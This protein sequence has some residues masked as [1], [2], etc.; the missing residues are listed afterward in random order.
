MALF[1]LRARTAFL[2]SLSLANY[3]EFGLIVAAIGAGNG[4]LGPEWLTIIAIALSLSF[5]AASPLN[6][7][8]HELYERFRTRLRRVQRPE[9]IAAEAEI[10]PGDADVMV[11]GM[12]RVGTGAYDSLHAEQGQNPVGIDADPYIVAAHAQKGRNVIRGSAMDADFWQ[13]LQLD[14]GSIRL[15]L[16]ALPQLSENVFA[17]ERLVK[18][19][20]DGTIGAIAKF[21]DDEPALKEAG[22][23]LVFDF[24]AEA[25]SGFARHVY[26]ASREGADG[27]DGQ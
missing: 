16:L 24:Y 2:A 23:T 11:I 13:R 21:P 3:S 7:S 26:I 14:N 20:F 12:G 15:V 6:A 17:A 8:S 1:K 27:R 9:R 25:G 19:G 10:D 5:V 22:V 18:G 4:W